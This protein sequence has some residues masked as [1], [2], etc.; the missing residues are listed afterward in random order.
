MSEA[1][2]NKENQAHTLS[3]PPTFKCF[4]KNK[5]WRFHCPIC[6]TE[7]RH[8]IGPGHRVAHCIKGLFK[9]TGYYLVL[10]KEGA[11]E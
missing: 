11:T 7:H 10:N 1:S 9:K 6:K 3:E 2:M 4:E 8:G 5:T